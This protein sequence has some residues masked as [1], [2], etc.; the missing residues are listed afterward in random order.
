MEVGAKKLPDA[1]CYIGG[2]PRRV[3]I[4][5]THVVVLCGNGREMKVG[6]FW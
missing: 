4:D 5:N 3:M 6:D 2:V 1:L